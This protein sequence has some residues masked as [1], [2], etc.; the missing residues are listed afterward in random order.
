MEIKE[1]IKDKNIEYQKMVNNTIEQ[2]NKI[3][4]A[5]Q[6]EDFVFYGQVALKGIIEQWKD[7]FREKFKVDGVEPEEFAW[8]DELHSELTSHLK[9]YRIFCK[10]FRNFSEGVSTPDT[11]FRKCP[12]PGCGLVWI[13][14]EGCD[15]PTTCGARPSVLDR[16]TKT[17]WKWTVENGVFR[18]FS[19]VFQLTNPSNAVQM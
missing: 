7:E 2:A 16:P 18:F 3:T 4:E 1:Y 12:H 10:N 19:E 5:A 9:R 13:K 15:G 8:F 6:K 14:V 11:P 17:K